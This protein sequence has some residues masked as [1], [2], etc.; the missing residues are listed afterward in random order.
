MKLLLDTSTPLCRLTLVT[1]HAREESE[2]QAD[3]TLADGLLTYIEQRLSVCNATLSDID[4]IG[5][6]KGPGS[7]TGLRIGV[8]VTNTLAEALVVPIVGETM[9]ENWQQRAI[10][11]L[12]RGDND[13]AVLPE[14]GSSANI[15]KTRK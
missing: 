11:R 15:T 5:I 3:R 12:D 13:R 10:Q 4:G 9:A 6:M 2:W 7:F 1:D 8:T 14:Y